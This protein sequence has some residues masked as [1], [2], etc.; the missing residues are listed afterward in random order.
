MH[1]GVV[2]FSSQLCLLLESST[3]VLRPKVKAPYFRQISVILHV[4]IRMTT[5]ASAFLSSIFNKRD[6]RY[7]VHG[8]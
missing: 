8:G 4:I 5:D 2:E 7:Y 3:S 1:R 6:R